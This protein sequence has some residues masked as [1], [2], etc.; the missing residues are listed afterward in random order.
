M[1]LGL[2]QALFQGVLFQ[3]TRIQVTLVRVALSVY[4][5][6]VFRPL[7]LPSSLRLFQRLAP[8]HLLSAI[9]VAVS[10]FGTVSCGLD[11]MPHIGTDEVVSPDVGSV[12]QKT[13]LE[14][15]S[16]ALAQCR[17][18]KFKKTEVVDGHQAEISGI[19]PFTDAYGKLAL[20]TVD[21]GGK[22]LAWDLLTSKA[23]RLAK[24]SSDTNVLSLSP[25]CDTLAVGVGNSIFL[26][27]LGKGGD[28]I[29]SLPKLKGRVT[30]VYYS[31]MGDSVVISS[32]DGN[33]YRWRYPPSKSALEQKRDF[34]RYEGHAAIPSSVSFHPFGRVFFSGDW[35]GAVYAWLSYD[36][37]D[38]FGG[39]YDENLFGDSFFADKSAR[40]RAARPDAVGVE[41]LVSSP[42]GE[43]LFVGLRTGQIELWQVRGFSLA[44]Q[45]A[46]HPGLIYSMVVSPD[47]TRLASSGR[48]GKVKIWSVSSRKQGDKPGAYALVLEKEFPIA[49][50][51]KLAFANEDRLF[52][53]CEDGKLMDLDLSH[54]V[55][56]EGQ[57]GEKR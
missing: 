30:S 6:P 35:Q 57:T 54:I 51:K 24:L 11:L 45:V 17:P 48:D 37:D 21:K 13:G 4:E 12:K 3:V 29:A 49:A 9:L 1:A 52:V 32:V 20:I 43:L 39:K 10:M 36:T 33:V 44:N 40:I 34:E 18:P 19:F 16:P 27:S 15:P 28:P 56:P 22:V 2:W 25:D 46:A 53:G 5:R 7:T 55:A 47:G 50:A 38:P 41:Q 23:Y 14:S 8:R 42:K 31:P 26:Y